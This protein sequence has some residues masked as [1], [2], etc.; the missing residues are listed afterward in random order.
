MRTNPE[1]QEIRALVAASQAGDREAFHALY[2]TLS[3]R[4]F[5]F[6][7]ARA[8][9]RDEAL[10]ALQETFIDFW[11]GLGSFTYQG[12]AAL[13]AFLY[14]IATRKIGR[15]FRLWRV[16]VHLESVQ[17]VIPTDPAFPEGAAIDA[18]RA[19]A[20]LKPRDREIISLRHIEGLAFAEISQLLGESENTL[21]VRHHRAMTRIRKILENA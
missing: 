18:A 21:K 15:T 8:R 6:V 14:R 9:N 10:D 11:K 13:Y 12:D 3:P 7:R 19:L 5:R 2:D 16:H 4:L 20:K 17:D 1:A